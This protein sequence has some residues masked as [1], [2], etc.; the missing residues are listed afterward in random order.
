MEE[1]R[2]IHLERLRR[3]RSAPRKRRRMRRDRKSTRPPVDKA[4]MSERLQILGRYPDDRISLIRQDE[5]VEDQRSNA[6]RVL[7]ERRRNEV[8]DCS[9]VGEATGL[10]GFQAGGHHD[11]PDDRLAP[12]TKIMRGSSPPAQKMKVD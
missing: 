7:S 3:M 11:F 8:E 6:G 10:L 1:D 5:D 4:L 12:P 2:R 9:P